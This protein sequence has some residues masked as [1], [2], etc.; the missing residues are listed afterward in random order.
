[1]EEV[2]KAFQDTM[3]TAP[4]SSF[5]LF[6]KNF[7][8]ELNDEQLLQLFEK[9]GQIISHAVMKYSNG[10]SKGFGFVVFADSK[11]AES[12]IKELDGYVLPISKKKLYVTK[13]QNKDE[14]QA[15][16]K[17]SVNVRVKNLNDFVTEEELREYFKTFGR[18]ISVKMI[19]DKN[20]KS[21]GFGFVRFVNPEDAETVIQ[22]LNG[23][24][25]SISKKLH[26]EKGRTKDERQPELAQNRSTANNVFIRNLDKSINDTDLER[27][28]QRFGAIISAKVARDGFGSSK[29][30]GFVC[31][32]DPQSATRAIQSMNNQTIRSKRVYVALHQKKEDRMKKTPNQHPTTG[33]NYINIPRPFGHPQHLMFNPPNRAAVSLQQQYIVRNPGLDTPGP[34]RYP[35]PRILNRF[36]RAAVPLHH[37]QIAQNPGPS[38][39][40]IP[41][42]L[43]H[44]PKPNTPPREGLSL[45]QRLSSP[46]YSMGNFDF[47]L[48]NE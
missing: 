47:L 1:M 8:E 43:N 38:T 15:E 39:A 36:T 25:V 24:A 4:T 35:Q 9:Y 14:R 40:G 18:I 17:Q 10:K 27:E 2:I 28:F 22:N 5:N 19:Y 21:R 20:N 33:L 48:N 6:V 30:F 29:G 13:A 7:E 32:E 42:I 23:R 34:S 37:Q 3:K 31:F 41:E 44:Q 26:I 46:N 16:L 12:A 45:L 11:A